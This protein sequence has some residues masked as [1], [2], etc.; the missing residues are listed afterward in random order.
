MALSHTH[1]KHV[2]TTWWDRVI[3]CDQHQQRRWAPAAGGG[4][5]AMLWCGNA[6]F[7]QCPESRTGPTPEL[8]PKLLKHQE[9]AEAICV[10]A[11]RLHRDTP[12]NNHFPGGLFTPSSLT[13]WIWT[14]KGRLLLRYK[15]ALK[16]SCITSVFFYRHRTSAEFTFKLNASQTSSREGSREGRRAPS[17]LDQ[18]SP[19]RGAAQ[20]WLTT[21]C[22][23]VAVGLPP[24]SSPLPGGFKD[25]SAG[26]AGAWAWETSDHLSTSTANCGSSTASPHPAKI[27]GHL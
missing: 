21:N 4:P 9:A 8:H 22:L 1:T 11:W 6:Q 7:L 14:F 23:P 25:L 24:G 27:H 15:A 3:V 16:K 12:K 13:A 18:E 2:Q 26:V 19:R 5:A 17:L 20:Q 10:S